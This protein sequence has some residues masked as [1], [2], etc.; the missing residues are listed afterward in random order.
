MNTNDLTKVIENTFRKQVNKDNRIKNAY[1]L[2]HSEKAGVHIEVAEGSTGQ[3]PASIHQPNYMA[4]VGKLFTATLIGILV[5]M[6]KLSFNDKIGKYLDHDLMKNLHV[7]KEKDYSS[8]IEIRH[9]LNHTS[10]LK[11]NFRTLLDELLDGKNVNITPKE[12]ILWVKNNKNPHFPPNAKFKYTDTNYHLLGLIIENI[13]GEPFHVVL[14]KYIF[15]P[16]EMKHS[17]MN[18]YSEPIEKLPIPT[19]EFFY[20]DMK[21]NDN[22]GYAAIDYTGGG[23]IAPFADLLKF[24]KAL[25]KHQ[26]LKKSTFEDMQ[27]NCVKFGLGIDYGYSIWKIKTVPVVMPKQFNSW[28]VAGATGAFMFYHPEKDFYIIGNFNDFS[29]E[30]KGLRFMLLNVIKHI[31]KHKM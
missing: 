7:Y 12:A 14:K 27:N 20:K 2:V 10:G 31:S 5:D 24:M 11:D 13:T 29:Y 1:L 6:G 28:G 21:L 15:E 18:G 16:L 3:F 19:A 8:E 25:V 23:V 4:S 30:V 17:Y 22:K 9:L 26:I